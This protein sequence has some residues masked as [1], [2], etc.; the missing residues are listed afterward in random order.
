M[1][2]IQWRK[3]YCVAKAGIAFSDRGGDSKKIYRPLRERFGTYRL[4][5]RK[6]ILILGGIWVGK[7]IIHKENRRPFHG[8]NLM[9]WVE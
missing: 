9:G 6:S 8:G 2:G 1:F 7:S 5:R 3:V 4:R